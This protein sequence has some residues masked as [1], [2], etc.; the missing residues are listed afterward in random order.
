MTDKSI[1][2]GGLTL[3]MWEAAFRPGMPEFAA[4]RFAFTGE[5]EGQVRIAFGN[6]GPFVNEGQRAPVY[7]H[8]VTLSPTIAV[9]LA[10]VLIEHYAN[11]K[12]DLKQ[13]IAKI[14]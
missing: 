13:P 7:T 4:S 5:A 14:P 1:V 11:P 12:D 2:V 9:E 8:A 6:L 3:A 10:R